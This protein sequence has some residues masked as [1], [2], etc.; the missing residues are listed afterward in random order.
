[1][2]LTWR[3]FA[4]HF[5]VDGP[6]KWEDTSVGGRIRAEHG[7]TLYMSPI[8]RS[9]LKREVLRFVAKAFVEN[10]FDWFSLD[11][12]RWRV[13]Y[14]KVRTFFKLGKE[15]EWLTGTAFVEPEYDTTERR[16]AFER[17]KTE[18][19]PVVTLGGD[20]P[21]SRVILSG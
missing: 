2:P 5:I 13:D 11:G 20:R 7:L 18:T 15:F 9:P 8:W 21:R 17:D 19:H 4:A 10:G 6:V 16:A 12:N 1:M 3:V 14:D